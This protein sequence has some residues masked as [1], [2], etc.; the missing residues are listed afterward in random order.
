MLGGK[1]VDVHDF[2]DYFVMAPLKLV[3]REFCHVCPTDFHDYFVMAPLKPSNK[4]LITQ[5]YMNFHDYFVM[6]PL[7]Q[8]PFKVLCLS[9]VLP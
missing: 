1:L 9:V 7:K 5:M 3:W 6:A 4:P 8:I 2:H